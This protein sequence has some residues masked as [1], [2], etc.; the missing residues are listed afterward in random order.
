MR[1]LSFE[2]FKKSACT[3][4]VHEACVFG[5]APSVI[6]ASGVRRMF[7]EYCTVFAQGSV[8]SSIKITYCVQSRVV[9]GITTVQVTTCLSERI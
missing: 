5:R 6:H 4:N 7:V 3:W 8:I 9:L 1:F 2:R